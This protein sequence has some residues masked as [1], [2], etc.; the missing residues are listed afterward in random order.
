[1]GHPRRCRVQAFCNVSRHVVC[2]DNLDCPLYPL[3]DPD[4]WCPSPIVAGQACTVDADCGTAG[5]CING[6]AQCE[7][8]AP[9]LAWGQAGDLV[10]DWVIGQCSLEDGTWNAPTA[11][12]M[13]TAVGIGFDAGPPRRLYVADFFRVLGFE[14]GNIARSSSA[15][16]LVVGQAGFDRHIDHAG[17]RLP[18]DLSVGGFH[19]EGPRTLG[20]QFDRAVE[21]VAMGDM[22]SVW[23]T[24]LKRVLR[25][26]RRV[27]S[28]PAADLVLGHCD[29]E[30]NRCAERERQIDHATDIA[31]QRRCSAGVRVGEPCA[32]DVQCAGSRCTTTLAVA[33]CLFHRVA[34][35]RCPPAKNGETIDVC[36]G[37]D[38]CNGTASNRGGAVTADSLSCPRSVTFD[39]EGHLWVLDG[40][41]NRVLRFDRKFSQEKHPATRVFGQ[42][43]FRS[44]LPGR[45][46]GRM[47]TTGVAGAGIAVDASDNLAIA[48]AGNSRVLFVPPPYKEAVRVIGQRDFDSRFAGRSSDG[49][50]CDAVAVP[51][52]VAFDDRNNLWVADSNNG[53]ALRFPAGF[54]AFGA[55]ADVW[56]GQ[57]DCATY[58]YL[59]VSATSFGRGHNRGAAVLRSGKHAGLGCF[60]D[61]DNHRVLCW[62][63]VVAAR[64]GMP[65]ADIVLGQ[66]RF[67]RFRA[68]D[69]VIGAPTLHQPALMD[70]VAGDV[71]RLLVADHSNNR[72]LGYRLASLQSG[73]A[74]DLVFGQKGSF[75]TTH[76]ADKAGVS[77]DTLCAPTSVKGDPE[78]NVW[79]VDRRAG[80]VLLYCFGPEG[81]ASGVCS[82]ENRGDTSADLVLGKPDL[83]TGFATQLCEAP[84]AA[85]LCRPFDVVSDPVGKRVFV[86]DQHHVEHAGRI[87]IYKYPLADGMPA[88]K[89][90]GI[91]N[92]RFNSYEPSMHGVCAG[93]PDA[94]R[95]CA[96]V[97]PQGASPASGRRTCVGGK[98]E[99]AACE[100]D[101]ACPGGHCGCAGMSYCDYSRSLQTVTSVD[102]LALHPRRDVLYVGKGPHILEYRAPF[103]SG[104]SASRV[105]G[106]TV[107]HNFHAGSTGYTECQWD[108]LAGG[109][110][111][112]AEDNLYVPQG[113]AENFTGVIVLADPAVGAR[114]SA[115]RLR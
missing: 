86:S 44:S 21:A 72:V 102:A 47:S 85:T 45:G 33:D 103:E 2:S 60:G 111:F 53:R 106:Y 74:A 25:Y 76:C 70:F 41:N 56:L 79:V 75:V 29:L 104:M 99:H 32:N 26:A 71:E 107:P 18:G 65:P 5:E 94:G 30:G 63:D 67:D 90:I 51:R 20:L 66:R 17:H 62:R 19:S 7:Y 8:E 80:R 36:L 31:A 96:Y 109:L 73:V 1:M 15:A 9:R 64:S 3:E 12:S 82:V 113:G 46:P 24:D 48:D 39:S 77:P 92:G 40:D 49:K 52:D 58:H 69:P 27:Q 16:S 91:P 13:A 43:D 112:D 14:E 78:G 81:S 100:D 4:D 114:R 54:P 98:R 35:W 55:V 105:G 93:G 88:T 95:P 23:I 11:S 57:I 37:Q 61:T 59:G 84:G 68:N 42:P 89:V 10:G 108:R 101:A 110:A 97:E 50:A 22:Q 6:I 115:S 28:N 38:D 87:L 34:V 83:N